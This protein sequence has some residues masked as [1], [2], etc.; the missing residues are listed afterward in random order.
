MDISDLLAESVNSTESADALAKVV[1]HPDLAHLKAAAVVVFFML[2]RDL[3]K[4]VIPL[5]LKYFREQL[6]EQ[7]TPPA[8]TKLD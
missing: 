7:V 8:P 1:E 6:S 4:S 5:A 3:Y 2:C